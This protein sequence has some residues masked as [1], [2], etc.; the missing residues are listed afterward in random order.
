MDLRTPRDLLMNM[1]IDSAAASRGTC[2]ARLRLLVPVVLAFGIGGMGCFRATGL[3]RPDTAVEEIPTTGGD[4]VAG[5]KATA[6]PGD[7]FLGN[8]SVEL[9]V[10]GAAFGDRSGQFGA[11]SG[12][13]ILDAGS[14]ALDQSYHRVSMPT[15]MLERLG[16]V[17]NQD[18][19]LPLVFDQYIP[20]SGNNS[21]SLVMQG[22]LLDPKG[23]LGVATDAQGRVPGVKVSHQITLNQGQIFFTLVTAL[24]NGSGTTLPVQNLGDRGT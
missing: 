10:D 13:A 12:G 20:R 3:S 14:I 21:A 1:S 9:A 18:P 19:D 15:D 4:R 22:Y 6:G 17:A 24:T 23:K 11:A 8:D 2:Q 7:F 16:P 5:L